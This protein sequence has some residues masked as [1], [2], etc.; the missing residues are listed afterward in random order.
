MNDL[1]L[2]FFSDKWKAGHTSTC[3]QV[4]KSSWIFFLEWKSN[5]SLHCTCFTHPIDCNWYSS[6]LF[7][8]GFHYAGFFHPPQPGASSAWQKQW[9]CTFL[10]SW[11]PCIDNGMGCNGPY[12]CTHQPSGIRSVLLSSTLPWPRLIC[13]SLDFPI[14][15]SSW[16]WSRRSCDSIFCPVVH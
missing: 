1:L 6:W 14:N 11:N 5:C 12:V 9:K 7:G 10:S 2:I 16:V 4:R 15:Y 8:S 3:D 13:T